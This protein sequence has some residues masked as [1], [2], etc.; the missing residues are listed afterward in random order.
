MIRQ[1]GNEGVAEGLLHDNAAGA[2]GHIGVVDDG[3]GVVA[4]DERAVFQAGRSGGLIV[5]DLAAGQLGV[6]TVAVIQRGL[7]AQG[8]IGHHRVGIGAHVGIVVGI[9]VE[10]AQ[11]AVV[12]VDGVTLQRIGGDALSLAELLIGVVGAGRRPVMVRAEIEILGAV[13]QQRVIQRHGLHIA[14]HIAE[15]LLLG[16][17]LV[18]EHILAV[19]LVRQTDAG[20]EG[21]G[22]HIHVGLACQ[23]VRHSVHVVGV[24]LRGAVHIAVHLIAGVAHPVYGIVLLLVALELDPLIC[25][26]GV[27]RRVGI[28]C[29]VV[30]VVGAVGCRGSI[31]IVSRRRFVL[32]QIDDDQHHGGDGHH[33]R[34]QQH[35]RRNATA[36][37]S[38]TTHFR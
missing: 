5:D 20:A 1:E 27:R 2:V 31:G 38:V 32:H 10:S 9:T 13:G 29:A 4:G 7:R 16:L 15:D 26:G 37:A 30:T 33:Q 23:L 3:V 17:L 28:V 24:F 22:Q 36:A 34:D 35:Q 18:A 25:G 8:V 11:E 12:L 6:L 21:D 14:V 19:Q